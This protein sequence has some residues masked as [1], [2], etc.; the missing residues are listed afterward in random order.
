MHLHK[1]EIFAQIPGLVACQT[2]RTGNSKE[3]LYPSF[4]LGESVGDDLDV[5]RSNKQSLCEGLGFDLS[6]LA[7][8]K[9]VHGNEVLKV[10]IGGYQEGFDALI[11]NQE[12][13]L[14]AVTIAD[15]VPI[16]VY[17]PE[18]KAMAAIHSGWKG[19]VKNI[20][21]NTLSAMQSEFGSRPE[22]MMAFIGACISKDHYEV[23][24]EVIRNFD[25]RF[26]VSG[27]KEG[28]YYLDLKAACLSQ[29]LGF[30]LAHQHVEVSALCTYGD[31]H[32]FYSHR[33]EMGKTGRMLAVIGRKS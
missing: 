1:P 27:I 2:T 13:V 11:S 15:C 19:T 24:E 4:N 8:S 20:I 18:N 28:K 22:A 29:L 31:N 6:Q 23:G 14:L 26:Y 9:Q 16:L 32:L 30:G 21:G 25:N 7:K 3:G 12:D 5:V 33:K 17:D 10:N